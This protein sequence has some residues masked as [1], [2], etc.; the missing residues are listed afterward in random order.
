MM[1]PGTTWKARGKR[2][3]YQSQLLNSCYS[4]P[5]ELTL[6]VTI[7]FKTTIAKPLCNQETPGQ[8]PLKQ[9]TKLSTILRGCDFRLV[10]MLAKKPKKSREITYAIHRNNSREQT[11]SNTGNKAA[12]DHH[13]NV[14]RTTLKS[15]TE[16]RNA[17]T[18]E[19]GLPTAQFVW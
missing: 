14:P 18:N 5:D 6:E 11:N 7:H 2:P 10:F 17:S 16:N 4:G 13:W 1:S 15:T 12:S 3:V 8:H 9:T 19:N